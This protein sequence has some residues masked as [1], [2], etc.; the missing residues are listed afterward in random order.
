MFLGQTPKRYRWMSFFLLPDLTIG[1]L[2]ATTA[3]CPDTDLDLTFTVTNE[4]D[5]TVS[6][7]MPVTFI[8]NPT[9]ADSTKLNTSTVQIS[10]M[11]KNGSADF[12]RTVTGLGT[13]NFDWE[14]DDLFAVINESGAIP[15]I[16][17]CF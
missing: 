17:C 6:G 15:H 12:T 2:S 8:Q 4:G 1:G 14:N 9:D 5:L 13:N 11:A 10:S 16:L 3:G 7:I